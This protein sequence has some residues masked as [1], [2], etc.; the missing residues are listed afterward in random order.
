MK[1]KEAR[2]KFPGYKFVQFIRENN[3]VNKEE[4]AQLE[5]E[6]REENDAIN[7]ELHPEWN[8]KK[9]MKCLQK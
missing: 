7:R 1:V 8:K 5:K 4:R 3:C 2:V 9:K 6:W